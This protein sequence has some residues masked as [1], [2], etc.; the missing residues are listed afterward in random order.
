MDAI[1]ILPSFSRFGLPPRYSCS[2]RHVARSSS[3]ALRYC[4]KLMALMV[5]LFGFVARLFGETKHRD[6]GILVNF[7][8]ILMD[9]NGTLM[10][11]NRLY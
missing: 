8:G 5:P 3:A 10:D 11:I 4:T 9:L 7:N 2:V 1:F 6:L